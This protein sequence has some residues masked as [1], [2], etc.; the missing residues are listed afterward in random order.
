M[1]P[2][3]N[4]NF[5]I[6]GCQR[7]DLNIYGKSCLLTSKISNLMKRIFVLEQGLEQGLEQ[8]DGCKLENIFQFRG[9]PLDQMIAKKPKSWRK[10]FP[11]KT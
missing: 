11:I 9:I 8:T 7:S 3:W 4:I 10:L 6:K 1:S 5:L 2:Q